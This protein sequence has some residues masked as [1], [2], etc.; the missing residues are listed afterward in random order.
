MDIAAQYL[1]TCKDNYFAGI[2]PAAS[3]SKNKKGY[4]DLIEI[5]QLYFIQKI[6]PAFLWNT[7]IGLISGQRICF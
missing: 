5:A 1:F 6:L 2:R 4:K 7:N 3:D